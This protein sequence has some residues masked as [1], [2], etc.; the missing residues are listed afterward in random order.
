MF[1]KYEGY[2]LIFQSISVLVEINFTIYF[3]LKAVL[4]KIYDTCIP[5]VENNNFS[6]LI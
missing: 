6:T 1:L 3:I 5:T 2:N 4:N